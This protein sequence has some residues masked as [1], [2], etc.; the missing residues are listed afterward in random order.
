M[1]VQE[2]SAKT[3]I[4]LRKLAKENSVTLGAGVSKSDI[5]QKLAAALVNE[6]AALA[7]ETPVADVPQQEPAVQAPLLR[8]PPSPR[9]PSLSPLQPSPPKPPH[10]RSSG[11]HGIIPH[12]GIAL[13]LPIKPRPIPSGRTGSPMRPA[14]H[15][16]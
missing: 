13:S 3:V 14:P 10:S 16:V 2:L 6:P 8:L 15:P 5:V 9:H 7:E 12:R 11:Q 4:E 1:T